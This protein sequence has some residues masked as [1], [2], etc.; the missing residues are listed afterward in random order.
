MKSAII[1]AAGKGTRMKS[2]KPKCMHKVCDKAMLDHLIDEAQKAGAEKIVT[3]VGHGH[4]EIERALEGRVEF[5]LQNPQLGTGHAVMQATQCE[6]LQGLTLV[7]NGDCPCVTQET[8]ER[9]YEEAN[10]Y[11]M[12]VLT[13]TLND[14]KAY[15]RIIR[16]QQGLIEKIVEFKDCTEEEKK[17]QEINTG[18]Y[19]FNNEV[20]FSNLKELK[21][22]NAQS[23]YYITDLVEVLNQKGL[24]V[25]AVEALDE[26]E[27]AGVNDQVELAQANK[28]MRKK[29]NKYWMSQGVVMLDP[30]TTY[31]GADVTLAPEVILYP[32]VVLEGQTTIGKGTTIYSNCYF[33][34]ATVGEECEILSTQ[35][36]DS[37]V[38]S[39]CHV[40]PF[41]HLRGHSV[42]EEK[43]RIGNFVEFKNTTFGV[44]SR[45]AHL[46][47][48]GDSVV[49]SKVNIG[50][51]VVT[52]NYD[53]KNKF[54]TT[55]E[56]GAFIGSNANLIAPI[57]VGTNAVVAAGSTVTK[58]V[59]AGDLAIA[60][61][62]QENK[63]GYGSKYK[64]KEK[65]E[66]E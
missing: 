45:C 8:M 31:I 46:T 43:N 35:I 25:G 27:V 55:I 20:L 47:Y 13:V 64:N 4:E 21:N 12:V 33:K 22:N 10:R 28:Y 51:G 5:A 23:E 61:S 3:I 37:E 7:I 24:S 52:V 44:D 42:V 58:D 48:L 39:H 38:K 36:F 18:I 54:K 30:K 2:E 50:C 1:M 16:N 11:E 60:R 66:K 15:G 59:H 65:G 56:D 63:E 53:G 17:I 40:G 26:K 29:I 49:G 14:P 9:L 32:N 57:T 62:R 41:A 19:A 6:A 34:N